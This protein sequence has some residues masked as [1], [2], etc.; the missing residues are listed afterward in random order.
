MLTSDTEVFGSSHNFRCTLGAC[1]KHDFEKWQWYIYGIAAKVMTR[2]FVM[3]WAEQQ[4]RF[5]GCRFFCLHL[6]ESCHQKSRKFMLE[7]AF[8]S[9]KTRRRTDRFSSRAM[10]SIVTFEGLDP[11]SE[12]FGSTE[13]RAGEERSTKA[14]PAAWDELGRCYTNSASMNFNSWWVRKATVRQLFDVACSVLSNAS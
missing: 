2:L 6:A 3:F 4:A 11:D 9:K 8:G 1:F 12:A 14:P 13:S 7:K 10:P 5:I